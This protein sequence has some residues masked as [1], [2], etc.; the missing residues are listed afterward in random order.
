[1]RYTD[2]PSSTIGKEVASIS[3]LQTFDLFTWL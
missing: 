1:L 3:I 2:H